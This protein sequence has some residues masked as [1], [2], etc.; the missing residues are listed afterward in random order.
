MPALNKIFKAFLTYYPEYFQIRYIDE[1]GN[2]IVRVQSDKKTVR[3]TP[4]NELQKKAEYPY[5]TETIKLKEGDIYYSD[6]NLNREYGTIQEPHVSVFR[7][8][9]PVYDSKNR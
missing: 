9:T 1:E 2:E 3:V 7:I 8:A 5:F 4:R 6:V